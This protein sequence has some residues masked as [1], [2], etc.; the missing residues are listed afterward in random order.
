VQLL[1]STND[2]SNN[3]I[4]DIFFPSTGLSCHPNDVDGNDP[5]SFLFKINV[6]GQ[7]FENTH[8]DNYQVYDYTPWVS[9]HPGGADKIRAFADVKN[10]FVLTF[11]GV[12]HSMKRWVSG[13]KHLLYVGREGDITTLKSLPPELLREDVAQA[14]G[15][16]VDAIAGIGEVI[17]CGSP[18]EVATV[19]DEKSGPLKK[20]TTLNYR[21]LS[22][23]FPSCL[24]HPQQPELKAALECTLNSILP[25][26]VSVCRGDQSGWTL[27]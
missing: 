16:A 1:S 22:C 7:C 10:T 8:P 4:R 9:L 15:S 12:Q 19:H 21:F 17:V 11:P 23:C 13:K 18:F 26:G 5:N 3:K 27:H 14:F 6:N 2:V 20:G 24:T 25:T